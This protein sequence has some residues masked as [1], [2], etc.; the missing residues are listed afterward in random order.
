MSDPYKFPK[1]SVILPVYLNDWRFECC[2]ISIRNQD[3]MPY[4]I[5]IVDDSA[6]EKSAISETAKNVLGSKV[7]IFVNKINIGAGASRKIAINEATGE[8]LA[9][10]DSDDCWLHNKLSTQI[11]FMKKYN[12]TISGHEYIQCFK[13][14]LFV[15]RKNSSFKY[16]NHRQLYF[17]SSIATPTLIIKK[18]SIN[19]V[20]EFRRCDDLVMIVSAASNVSEK[21]L[22]ITDF[23]AA[24]GFK[25]A[26]GSSGLTQSTKLMHEA[27][28]KA[29]FH[30]SK[31]MSI[32]EIIIIR[33]AIFI[34]YLKYPL[35]NLIVYFR[36]LF[37]S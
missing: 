34:E 30:L 19:D 4:E 13:P 31:K 12:S 14:T 17:R 21:I 25:F 20:V 18:S 8:Y 2:L 28:L 23:P 33:S 26:T 5:I 27:F 9:F 16:I 7:K 32:S 29:L 1:V 35:R 15:P 36:F 24:Y 11:F 10:I 37:R 6:D 22:F 3:L